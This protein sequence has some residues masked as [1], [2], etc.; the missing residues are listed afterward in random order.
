MCRARV[1][2]E[3]SLID[4]QNTRQVDGRQVGDVEFFLQVLFSKVRVC[5]RG[6]YTRGANSLLYRSIGN[7]TMLSLQKCCVVIIHV[8]LSNLVKNFKYFLLHACEN[9]FVSPLFLFFIDPSPTISPMCEVSLVKDNEI[10]DNH[11]YS[12]PNISP[13]WEEGI[14]VL[15]DPIIEHHEN[16]V[17]FSPNTS[18]TWQGIVGH[19]DEI[20]DTFISKDSKMDCID[21][22]AKVALDPP[23][24]EVFQV[25]NSIKVMNTQLVFRSL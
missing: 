3:N 13:T 6:I 9:E 14:L 25:V 1:L 23:S 16:L 11:V 12:S 15:E 17:Y 20:I 7:N 18:P 8:L 21:E 24:I 22:D 4:A 10:I 19:E 5:K 2:D